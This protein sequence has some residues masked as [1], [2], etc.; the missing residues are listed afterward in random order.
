MIRTRG[1]LAFS[2][3]E[4]TTGEAAEAN[5]FA[6]KEDLCT[7][8]IRH[9]VERAE[10][11]LRDVRLE[12]QD[13]ESRLISF[14]CLFFEDFEEGIPSLS[15]ALAA[16]RS[17]IPV[18]VRNQIARLFRLQLN[19]IQTVVKEHWVSN[20][21]PATISSEHAAHLLMCALEG[22]AITECALGAPEPTA[23]GFIQ[24]LMLLGISASQAPST[25]N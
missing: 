1:Y 20:A 24:A 16:A 15:H 6:S 25:T 22:D 5:G 12:F 3:A 10:S 11:A 21:N 14:A 4:L 8:L 18:S 17:E 9:K 2:L 13:A 19:W 7:L 23:T